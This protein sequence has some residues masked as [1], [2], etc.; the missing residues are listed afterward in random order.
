MASVWVADDVL[1]SRRVAVKTLHPELSFDEGL[2][3]RFR[4]EAVAAARLGHPAIVATY[5]TG[6]DEDVAYI[7]MELVDGPTV[8]RLLDEHG[9]LPVPEALR[10][11][12]EV[13]AAL[14]HAHR[15]GVVHRD[16]KPANVLVAPEGPVKVTDFGIAKAAGSSDLTR[17]GTV[18]GTARYLAPEQVDG[19]G[20]D[21]RT[22]VYAV[23][24]LLYEML[25]G[26]LPFG[27]DNEM[28]V[29]I[30]RL[31]TPAPSVQDARPEIPDAVARLVARCLERDSD[32]RFQDAAEL[33]AA[34][35]HAGAPGGAA[36]AQ[37]A[38][39]RR[40]PPP[41]AAPTVVAAPARAA[42]T[43]PSPAPRAPSTPTRNGPRSRPRPDARRRPPRRG[44]T[45]ALALFVLV[46]AGIAAYLGVR[47]IDRGGGGGGA[48]GGD[49]ASA[50]VIAGAHDFDPF[51]SD[52]R[53]HPEAVDGAIDTN[54]DTFWY[55]ETY[56]SQ[57]LGG[58]QGV[59]LIIELKAPA[60][61]ASVD[62]ETTQPGWNG[63]I[64]VA[65]Q[66][67]ATLDA[68]GP[69]RATGSDLG[70]RAHFALDPPVQG[71]AVLLWITR[72]PPEK[73]LEVTGVHVA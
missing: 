32:A 40:S 47:A 34:L 62:V 35:D 73:R 50:P 70:T 2:R 31:A 63:R 49:S 59:G 20:S 56:S 18:V 42:T 16:I 46:V 68:W 38:P 5:D 57:D 61:V 7:V 65:E 48:A 26:R 71:A 36:P 58:K 9:T 41:V 24:L 69:P 3:A 11:A 33:C 64:Y 67:G 51:S 14:D 37:H 39:P 60:D 15:H 66:A 8:R 4:R 55:T 10:I 72:L 17:T 21:E 13:T 25:V 43:T 12:R 29:A 54:P 19:R 30:A 22:D 45:I 44:P 1:L 27:G 52:H 28:A 53:E 6:E 23:G